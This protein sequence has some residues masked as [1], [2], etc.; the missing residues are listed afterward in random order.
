MTSGN[1]IAR[2]SIAAQAHMFRLAERDHG[3][4]RKVLHLE[5]GIPLSTLKSWAGDT[6]IPVYGLAL[7]AQVIPDH[8]TSLLLEPAGKIIVTAEEGDGDLDALGREC[9]GFVSDKLDAEADGRVTH[10]E[11]ARLDTRKRRIRSLAA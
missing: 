11:R 8:L 1:R 6:A 5:T 3:L 7:L 2:Q 4:T 10:I 9:A